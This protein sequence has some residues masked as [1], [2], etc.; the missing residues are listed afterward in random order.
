MRRWSWRARNGARL[1]AGILA[2]AVVLP[3]AVLPPAARA[4]AGPQ[5]VV[6]MTLAG[7]AR[8]S[9]AAYYIAFTVSDA[10]LAGPQPDS[11]NWTHYVVYREGRFGFGVVPQT[12]LQPFG[13]TAV[14]PPVP[15]PFGQVLQGGRALRAAIPLSSLQLGAGLPQRFMVNFVVTDGANR[16]QHALGLGRDDRFGFVT[17]EVRREPFVR[18]PAPR[19]DRPADPSLTITGGEIQITTP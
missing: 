4:Q 2:A 9:G 17:V 18:V 6:T 7:P 10:L 5:V 8:E 14:R 13:F 1:A 3:A 15:F 19:G 11:M 16:P 12:T